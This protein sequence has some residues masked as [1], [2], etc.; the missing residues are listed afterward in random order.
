[1]TRGI[2]ITAIGGKPPIFP[3]VTKPNMSYRRPMID[4]SS[5][6]LAINTHY[7]FNT[8]VFIAKVILPDRLKNQQKTH[9]L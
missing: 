3:E 8:Y 7:L 2:I 1:M 5:D 6:N 4:D 9:Y